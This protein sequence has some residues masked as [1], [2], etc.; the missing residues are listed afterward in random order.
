MT[1]D[2]FQ[3]HTP[4]MS[5]NMVSH[6]RDASRQ[7]AP[8]EKIVYKDPST[9]QT[10]YQLMRVPYTYIME[11][12]ITTEYLEDYYQILEQILPYFSPG[13]SI[14]VHDNQI[15][16]KTDLNVVIDST[17]STSPTEANMDN[18]RKIEGTLSFQI[19]GFMYHNT[20]SQSNTKLIETAYINY[21]LQD[22]AGTVVTTKLE[23]TDP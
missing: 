17:A 19:Q 12:S 6:Q 16:I 11:L 5:F 2:G 7:L 10:G 21:R 22:T 13:F 18:T 1:Y 23:V 20:P 15:G 4:R 3:S 8:M 9:G 14:T